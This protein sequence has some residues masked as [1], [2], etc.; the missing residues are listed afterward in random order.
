MPG[1][2]TLFYLLESLQNFLP[3]TEVPEEQMQRSGHQWRI[4]MH[5]QVQQDPQEGPTAVII[6]VQWGVLLTEHMQITH[7]NPNR[8]K[9]KALPTVLFE[10]LP[11][12]KD[13]LCL[14]F[15]VLKIQSACIAR[16]K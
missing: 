11:A 4:V 12:T 8:E 1:W 15:H 13:P 16:G 7:S 9:K 10:T 2:V 3:L 5:G 14:L 6:Q